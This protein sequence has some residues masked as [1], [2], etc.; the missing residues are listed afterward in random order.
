[1]WVGIDLY[2]DTATRPSPGMKKA[3]V[4]AMLGDEQRGEDPTTRKLEELMAAKLNKR[5]AMFFP[6]ATMCNQI[7]AKIHTKPGEEALGAEECHMFNSEGGALGFHS[8]VQPRPIK[9]DTGIF[10]VDDI[11]KVL[12]FGVGPHTPKA[13]VLLIENTTNAGGGHAWPVDVLDNV[14]AFA[15]SLGLKTHLDGSRLYNAAMATNTDVERLARG[16]D[17]VTICFSKGLACAA[18]AILAFDSTPW[19]EVRRL[20]QLFGGALRQS[21]MLAAACIYALEHHV[22]DLAND[23][24]RAGVLATGLANIAGIAVE[25]VTPTSNIVYFS[26]ESNKFDPESFLAACLKNNLRFSRFKANRFRAVT[27]RD[28]SD[29]DIEKA[30]SIVASL[31]SIRKQ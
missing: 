20:K 4:E 12:R 8:G 22:L 3:M 13:S 24:R 18:G 7:A 26:L 9:S 30:L 28:I 14:M 1:M 16:F 29:Q 19:E 11:R 15:K 2:S 17:S 5:S 23:H 6:S 25:N 27:H 31:M 21:G 10:N